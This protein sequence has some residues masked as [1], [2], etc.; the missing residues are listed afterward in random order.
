[1]N[2]SSPVA[3]ITA[4]GRGI[5]AACARELSSRGYDVA[6]LSPSGSAER[7]AG[8]LGGI[9]ITGSVTSDADLTLLV[10]TALDKW[11]RIDAVVNNTGLMGT[12]MAS[13]GHAIGP[14][15][16]AELSAYGNGKETIDTLP[17]ELWHDALDLFFLNIV[18]MCRLVTPVMMQQ[19]H[20]AIV[21]ITSNDVFEPKI[22][23]PLTPI[24]A[25]THAYTKMY[26]DKYARYGIRINTVAPGLLENLSLTPEDT[27]DLIPMSRLGSFGDIAQ[28]VAFLLSENAAYVTGHV[29]RV[30]GGMNRGI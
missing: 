20:G 11:G 16:R 27:R 2:S 3:V 23:F 13:R 5:G 14:L 26:A 28:A 8:E 7:L 30:D 22:A 19:R 17:D 12:L 1:M 21:N 4:A 9:G 25:A 15:G 10:N 24:R 18:R 29:L 6:L